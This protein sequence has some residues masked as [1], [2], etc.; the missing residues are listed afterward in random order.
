MGIFDIFKKKN[1]PQ[2]EE[3]ALPEEEIRI[4]ESKPKSEEQPKP[5]KSNKRKTLGNDFQ[6][7][8]DSKNDDEIIKF[9][10]RCEINACGGA[11]IRSALGFDISETVM[12][13]LVEQGADVNFANSYG[14]TPL[15]H[16]AGMR[17]GNVKH[18]LELGANVNAK[19]KMD[20]TPLINAVKN[21][22][23][24][25]IK[26]LVEAGADINVSFRGLSLVGLA[27]KHT[28]N[29]N[30]PDCVKVVEY[31]LDIG[32]CLNGEEAEYVTHIGENFEFYYDSINPDFI[33]ELETGLHRLYELFDVPPVSK[34]KKQ[35]LDEPIEVKSATWQKQHN[36]LWDLLV[37]AQN[38][39]N[40]IQGEII[41][42]SGELSYEILDNGR[43]NWDKE[44]V[45]MT[46][47]MLDYMKLGDFD[48]DALRECSELLEKVR[49]DKADEEELERLCELSVKFVLQ[50]TMPIALNQVAYNR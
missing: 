2:N 29:S 11:P 50:N 19:D 4:K 48:E 14:A 3:I 21:F 32:L 30:I 12:D 36:E 46:H 5:K 16:H 33:N 8:V 40:T 18:L 47:S 44:Y 26:T 28:S 37:P 43:M 7:L 45:K 10:K 13:W 22:R 42:I 17:T 35:K 31:L 25:N 38:H 49:T 34:L 6:K 20:A 41:R 9:L 23:A 27:L 39:A 15:H 24:E 1:I